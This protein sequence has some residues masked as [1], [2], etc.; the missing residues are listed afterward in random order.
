MTNFH[1]RFTSVL[2]YRGA[3]RDGRRAELT[4]AQRILDAIRGQLRDVDLAVEET[5]RAATAAPGPIN[6]DAIL[7]GSRYEALLR[8]QRS[9]IEAQ[10]RDVQKEVDRR[11]TALVAADQDVRALEQLRE[12]AR[13]R[14]REAMQRMEIAELDEV[15]ARSGRR[16]R[17]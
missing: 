13:L 5:R 1:F 15:G 3:I 10:E 11:R 8:I 12:K 14:H 9:S 17:A 4:E 7:A 6:V 16:E 2:K